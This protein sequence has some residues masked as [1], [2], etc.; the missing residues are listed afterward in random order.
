ML[1]VVY[2]IW[3][4]IGLGIIIL[5]LWAAI[6]KSTEAK[7]NKDDDIRSMKKRLFKIEER[8]K[9]DSDDDYDY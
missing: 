6:S 3:S 9:L 5:A 7:I 2:C 8:L 4:V 1:T